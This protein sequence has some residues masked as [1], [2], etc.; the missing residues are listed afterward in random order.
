[1]AKVQG[2]SRTEDQGREKQKEE[3][4]GIGKPPWPS[5]REEHMADKDGRSGP[6]EQY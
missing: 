3:E 6:D 5:M 1:M 4:E 2:L